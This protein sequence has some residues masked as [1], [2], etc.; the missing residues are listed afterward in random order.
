M[1]FISVLESK[2]TKVL[3][4]I[5]SLLFTLIICITILLVILR[6][7]FNTGLYG[8][9]ELISYLFIYTTALGASIAIG[10]DTH[11]KI[12]F[13]VDLLPFKIQK[14]IN[15]LVIFLV[16]FFNVALIFLS[17]P[18]IKKVGCFES[19]T[20]RIPNALVQVAVPLGCFIS[21]IYCVFKIIAILTKE[22][23]NVTTTN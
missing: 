5:I 8:G 13:I 1:N 6:Y 3:E 23:T 21:V 9:N 18:W 17:L 22:D 20:L 7:V 14:V 4:S 19:P 11:I 10:K 15:A 12:T 16:G 2:V